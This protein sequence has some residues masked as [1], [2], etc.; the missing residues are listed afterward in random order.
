MVVLLVIGSIWLL[1][2]LACYCVLWLQNRRPLSETDRLCTQI[3]LALMAREGE[4]PRRFV[5]ESD[6]LAQVYALRR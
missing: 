2:A 5:R 1:L 4:R 6:E 3:D